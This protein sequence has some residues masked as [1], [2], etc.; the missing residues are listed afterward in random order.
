MEQELTLKDYSHFLNSLKEKIAT[1]RY[2]AVLHV[3]KELTHLYHYIG[4]EILKKQKTHG[5]G[6]KIIDKLSRD[7]RFEFPDMKGFSP[8]NLKYMRKFAD[9]YTLDEIGQQ[10][11]DQ[12]P[13]GHN[14]TIMYEVSNK[15]ER[16]FYIQKVR[17]NGWSRNV[18]SMQIETKLYK[19]EGHAITNFNEKLPSAHSELAQATIRNPYLFDF[20]SLGKD[21]HEREIEKELVKHIEKFL[22]ALGEGFAFLGRQYHLQIDERDHYLDLLFYNVKL[23]SFIVVE[24]KAGAFKPEYAGKMNFYLSA[25]DDLIKHQSDNP[26]IG[27]ILC[28]TKTSVTAEYTL[29]DMTKPI[30]LAEY[31]LTEA[32]PENIKTS[33]P[34]IEELEAELSKNFNEP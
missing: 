26:S 32:L 15:Q 24:L 23:R 34:T 12:L 21:A 19:R 27:L 16:E 9:E 7:L 14:I 22:L 25:V 31:K 4:S 29:R 3:N 33:L 8:Q 5:W 11:I 30:G 13:W 2:K 20:V 18:L 1:T 28:R 10:A 17:E 6:S